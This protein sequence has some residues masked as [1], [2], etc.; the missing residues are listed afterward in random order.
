MAEHLSIVSATL[1]R[2]VGDNFVDLSRANKDPINVLPVD[3]ANAE[4]M[5]TDVSC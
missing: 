2:P 4:N 5:D 1:S 3:K